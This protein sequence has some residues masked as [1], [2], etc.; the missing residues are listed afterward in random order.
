PTAENFLE[1][2]PLYNLQF[3]ALGVVS[4][5]LWRG[6]LR[7]GLYIGIRKGLIGRLF[8]NPFALTMLIC[9]FYLSF[10]MT[11]SLP[12]LLMLLSILMYLALG[13]LG[14]SPLNPLRSSALG[15]LGRMC[16]SF[17]LI[18][19]FIFDGLEETRRSIF[20]GMGLF[21]KPAEVQ[22]FAWG[23]ILFLVCAGVSWCTYR[24]IEQPFIRFG[25]NLL[26]GFRARQSASKLLDKG[27]KN[28]EHRAS[29]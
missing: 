4:Y 25:R 3:F 12:F 27:S 7:N 21:G 11:R 15:A 10:L 18:H 26:L 29:L 20:R 23:P 28:G 22:M 14:D 17:Y 16:Y 8:L 24:W 6:P 13:E 2:S 9:L 19:L 5:H 1:R